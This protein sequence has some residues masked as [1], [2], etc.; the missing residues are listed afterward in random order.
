VKPIFPSQSRPN[1]HLAEVHLGS[2]EMF[3]LVLGFGVV[4]VC[5]LVWLLVVDR[6]AR[7]LRRRLEAGASASSNE[8]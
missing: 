6:Q 2:E 8:A 5:H 1:V 3:Y 4:W 7:Q